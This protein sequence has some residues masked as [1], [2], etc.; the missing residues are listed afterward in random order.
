MQLHKQVETMEDDFRAPQTPR[1]LVVDDEPDIRSLLQEILEDEGFDVEIAENAAA[2]RQAYRNHQPDLIL[3]DIWMPDMDGISLLKEWIEE[4]G[5]PMPVIMMSGHGT[6]ETAVEA[7]RLGAF[8]FIEKPLSLTKLLHTVE[9]ALEKEKPVRDLGRHRSKNLLVSEP[10]GRSPVMQRLREQ[11]KRVAEHD[12]RVLIVGEPGS[13]TQVAA[14]YLHL[15]SKHQDK[16]F[17]EI[18]LA[19]L[20]DNTALLELFGSEQGSIKL[21]AFE[22]SDNGT[23]L[24]RDLNEASPAIQPRLLSALQEGGSVSRVTP[25]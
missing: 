18:S 3:L 12:S 15:N 19:G 21:G 8:D 25:R 23:L 22:S 20:D 7:T 11:I 5:L 13:G 10:I 14:Q 17:V 1:I 6:V 16:P 2:A 24:L 9:Q 4:S